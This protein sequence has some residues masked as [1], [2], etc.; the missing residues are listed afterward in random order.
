MVDDLH[1]DAMACSH[2]ATPHAPDA[3]GARQIGTFGRGKTLIFVTQ[4]DWPFF[5]HRLPLALAARDA[6]FRVMLATRFTRARDIIETTGIET[7]PLPISRAGM[8][9]YVEWQTYR[10]LVALYR[11]QKPDLVHHVTQ[12]PVV[13]GTLAARTAGVPAVV[14]ALGGLGYLFNSQ[15]MRARALRTALTPLMR[16]ALCDPRGVVVLQN[17]HNRDQLDA[18]GMIATAR[19]HMVRGAGVDPSAYPATSQASER[20]L[21]VLP[22]RLLRDKG[23]LEFV[24]AARILRDRGVA[25]RM[26]L[27][28]TPDPANPTSVSPDDV[29]GWVDA[30]LIEDF[31]W[32]DAMADVYGDAQIVCLPSYH[33][34][35]PRALL[36]GGASG[37]ALVT[38]DIPGCRAVVEH[39]V[40]GLLVPPRDATA[41]ADTLATLAGSQ[42]LRERLG[43]AAK[44]RVR[45]TFS[46][47]RVTAQMFEIYRERL[48]IA[49]P[50][51][52]TG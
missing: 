22:A 39:N 51:D 11:A 47:D 1:R 6:G 33:E 44:E 10:T 41:L 27:V 36:E 43:S 9:P 42:A 48:G 40:T 15:T 18:E 45:E 26:A 37:C 21:V 50:V 3:T 5:T 7:I 23:V 46:L 19:V 49:A 32:R 24:E 35:L 25:I 20:P 38:T 8:N 17:T 13:Y 31:G 30:G 14:N 4:E 28:G 34:G 52:V 16:L 12:K 2:V 29:Q